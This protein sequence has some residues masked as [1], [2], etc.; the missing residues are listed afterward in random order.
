MEI[1]EFHKYKIS[2]NHLT[3]IYI[4]GWWYEQIFYSKVNFMDQLFQ[5]TQQ[6]P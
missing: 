6:W 2:G 5:W 1:M 3:N 4:K